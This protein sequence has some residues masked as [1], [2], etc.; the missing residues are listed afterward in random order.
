MWTYTPKPIEL[1][2]VFLRKSKFKIIDLVV[3]KTAHVLA[4]RLKDKLNQS[5]FTTGFN[6][7]LMCNFICASDNELLFEEV[8]ARVLTS[9]WRVY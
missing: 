8:Y 9:V 5:F 6:P 4:T 3:Q 2:S 7:K 1:S